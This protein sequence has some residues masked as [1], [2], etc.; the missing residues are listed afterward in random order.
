MV[1]YP[2]ARTMFPHRERRGY[3]GT[4]SHFG[5]GGRW[6]GDA[7]AGLD[8]TVWQWQDL[9]YTADANL[10]GAWDVISIETADNAAHPRS[11]RGRHSS[12]RPSPNCRVALL[13]AGPRRLPVVVALPP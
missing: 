2:P 8:G 9:L 12:A 11:R 3:Q 13:A 10:D 6:G 7:K 4:E 5:V 1:G